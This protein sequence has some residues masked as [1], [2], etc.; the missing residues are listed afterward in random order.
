M[1]TKGDCFFL[2]IKGKGGGGLLSWC[3]PLIVNFEVRIQISYKILSNNITY[4]TLYL[5]IIIWSI[6]PLLNG[7][8]TTVHVRTNEWMTFPT[9]FCF[10]NPFHWGGGGVISFITR[11]PFNVLFML[12]LYVKRYRNDK[13]INIPGIARQFQRDSY[14]ISYTIVLTRFH[15][16]SVQMCT[17]PVCTCQTLVTSDGCVRYRET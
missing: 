14:G 11:S 10:K 6:P 5:F 8:R 12:H 9:Y 17:F 16:H 7:P 2:F 3:C 1:A 4:E 13:K 15:H